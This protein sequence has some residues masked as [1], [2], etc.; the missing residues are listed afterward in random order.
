MANLELMRLQY[1]ILNVP[2]AEIALAA[3]L[4]VDMLQAEAESQNWRQLWPDEN[5]DIAIE[6]GGDQFSVAADSYIE[7]AKKRLQAFSLAKERILSRKY[8][9]IESS[10][11]DKIQSTLDNMPVG[12]APAATVKALGSLFKE[13]SKTMLSAGALNTSVFN[14]E[15]SALPMLLV[16]DLSG[17]KSSGA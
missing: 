12:Q 9:E 16:R 11:L 1:E 13:M 4:P 7:N 10:L 8:F 14:T 15:G 2:I 6:E 5:V 3:N 17:Q